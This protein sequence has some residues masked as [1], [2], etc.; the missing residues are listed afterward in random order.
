M[1]V[2]VS[3]AQVVGVVLDLDGIIALPD[4]EDYGTHELL[5]VIFAE[6]K[7]GKKGLTYGIGG[8]YYVSD[9]EHPWIGLSRLTESFDLY[10]I[11]GGIVSSSTLPE[12]NITEAEG[13]VLRKAA[14]KLGT[15]KPK[16]EQFMSVLWY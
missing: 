1:G 11:P 14:K 10:D 12:P 3:I 8:S 15:S 2:D 4:W 5:E 13:K 16:V 6:E 9:N 7:W